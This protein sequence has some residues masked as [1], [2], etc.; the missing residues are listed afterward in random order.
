M[1]VNSTSNINTMLQLEKKLEE[2]AEA[3][4]K[5]NRNSNNTDT[6]HQKNVAKRLPMQEEKENIQ[7]VDIV[8]EITKQIEIP[9]AYSVNANV[10]SV[11]NAVHQSVLDIKV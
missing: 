1:Q 5:L 11:Q 2:S 3:L 7:D 8:E 10:I 9:I 6:E 4:T